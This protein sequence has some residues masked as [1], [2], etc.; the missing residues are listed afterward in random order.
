MINKVRGKGQTIRDKGNKGK[1]D[2]P[3]GNLKGTRRGY[4]LNEGIIKFTNMRQIE[5]IKVG[6]KGQIKDSVV[7]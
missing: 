7:R 1:G 2:R 3:K 4:Y 6:Q 5:V